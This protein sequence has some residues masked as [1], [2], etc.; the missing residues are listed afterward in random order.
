MADYLSP[1]S[2]SQVDAA[3]AIGL[4]LSGA[5]IPLL[6][7]ISSSGG[8]LSMGGSELVTSLVQVIDST[9]TAITETTP[10]VLSGGTAYHWTQPLTSLTV[11]SVVSNATECQLW[12]TLAS[13]G[14]LTWNDATTSVANAFVFEGG[15]QYV[16]AVLSNTILAA[17]VGVLNS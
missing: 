5:D 3:V 14:G 8:V 12:F 17:S 2:G 16:A 9:T 15:G 1:Y 10:I 11:D 4:A 13:N 7:T 6:K